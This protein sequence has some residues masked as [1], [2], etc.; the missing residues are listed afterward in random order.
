MKKTILWII[1]LALLLALSGITSGYT[2]VPEAAMTINSEPRRKMDF[3]QETYMHR[4]IPDA[5]PT[6][7]SY[8]IWY[9]WGGT[10][11]DAEKLP[12]DPEDDL[13]CWAAAASNILEW[14][15]WGLAGGMSNTDQMFQHFQDHWTD[16]GSLPYI[17]WYWWFDGTE[18]VPGP[19]WSH[20]DVPGGGNFW[21][22]ENF[23][24]YYVENWAEYQALSAIDTYLH[25]GYGV[26][27]AIYTDT[28]GGH[29][30]TCWG[31]DYDDLDPDYYVG[32][33]VTDSDDDKHLPTPPDTLRYYE[34]EYN[35]MYARWHLQNLYGSNSWWIG[36]VM[37]LCAKEEPQFQY[38]FQIS[39]YADIIHMDVNPGGWINGICVTASYTAPV[40][41]RYE[42]GYA[43]I[44]VDFPA[45]IYYD[46]MFMVINIKTRDGYMMRIT[47]DLT[48][49][50]PEYI[51]L[52]P[53]AAEAPTDGPSIAEASEAEVTP[54]A[55]YDFQLNP[56]IDIVS[57]NT[58][59]AP[60]LWGIQNVEGSPCYPCTVL[61]YFRMGKFY[62]AT[63]AVDG[64]D[65]CLELGFTAGTI[66]S[67]DG[68]WIVTD[69]GH[70]YYGPEYIW[71]TP[72]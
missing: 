9:D 12:G 31:Y 39:P 8:F 64:E 57:L 72:V 19:G 5:T 11:C 16:E 35:T 63:D 1:G 59:M 69:D 65:G 15:G 18:I 67:R 25:A 20:V 6:G 42:Y 27:L 34:V 60:W 66:A 53:V 2:I 14:T 52:T 33:H 21:P 46:Q 4:S 10:W 36:G 13:L 38:H 51:W 22:T 45:G 71:L 30:I 47:D 28:G 32:V 56:Y 37:G 43:Y 7:T 41:G 50:P 29:A 68:H 40:L 61:G 24:D 70:T 55:W 49:A 26:T 44:A 23:Y 3:D 17:A 54:Q 48:I 62:F 58:D